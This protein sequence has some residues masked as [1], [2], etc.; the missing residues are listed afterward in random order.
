VGRHAKKDVDFY[1]KDL[2]LALEIDGI[3]HLDEK[4]ILKD[5]KINMELSELGINILRFDALLV[6]NKVEA[7][8]REIRNWVI[9]YEKINGVSEFLTRKRIKRMPT[10]GPSQEGNK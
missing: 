7:V 6:L 4:V 2:L 10:P 3:T 9:E 5:D 1:C 8:L